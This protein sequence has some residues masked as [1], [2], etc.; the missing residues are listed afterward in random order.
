MLLWLIPESWRYITINGVA[1][2][3]GLLIVIFA[4]ISIAVNIANTTRSAEAQRENL[5]LDF[6]ALFIGCGLL[7][8]G[9]Y[10][11]VL[12][13]LWILSKIF[14]QVLQGLGNY[15]FKTVP[16]AWRIVHPKK[17]S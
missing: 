8:L 16:K 6:F 3:L 9:L 17:S 13:V 14:R 11:M 15:F 1:A 12:V 2:V 5:Q 4:F 10:S 7:A